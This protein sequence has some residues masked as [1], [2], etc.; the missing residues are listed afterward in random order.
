VVHVMAW[1]C[2]HFGVAPATIAGHRDLA[3]TACPGDRL[4]RYVA[5]GTLRRRTRREVGEV[6]L[7]LRCGPE[8]RRLV[9]RI[10]AGEA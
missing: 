2:R 6:A 7:R 3:A 9:R 1:A 4:H 10:E 5:D 8:G